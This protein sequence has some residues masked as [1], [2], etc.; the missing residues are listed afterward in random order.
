MAFQSTESIILDKRFTV[1][2]VTL[3]DAQ[4]ALVLFHACSQALIGANIGTLDDLYAD[5]QAPRFSMTESTRAV[6]TPD[7]KLV[8]YCEVH[9]DDDLPVHPQVWARVHPKFMNQGI[10]TALMTWGEQRARQAQPA[11]MNAPECTFIALGTPTK[12]NCVPATNS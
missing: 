3:A 10:G 9:D 1:R 6:F 7:G 2:P 12:K 5:W 8:G 11:C 4:A